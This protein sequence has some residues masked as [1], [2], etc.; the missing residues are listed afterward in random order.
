[1]SRNL[2]RDGQ[3]RKYFRWKEQHIKEQGVKRQHDTLEKL[4]QIEDDGNVE[5]HKIRLE[6]RQGPEAAQI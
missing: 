6:D 5:S 2:G 4:I 3:E 1:M